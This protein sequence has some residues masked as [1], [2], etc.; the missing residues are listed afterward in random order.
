MSRVCDLLGVG[1]MSGNNVSHSNR[2]TRRKFIPNLQSVSFSSVVFGNLKLRIAT[3]TL[4]TVTK[5]GGIDYFLVNCGYSKL[6]DFAK[7]LRK[8][9]RKN[10]IKNS[11]LEQIKFAYDPSQVKKRD[12]KSPRLIKKLESKKVSA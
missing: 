8:S 11:K 7:A 5:F 3:S 2:K 1:V 6:T 10:L 12:N 4:R 9:V